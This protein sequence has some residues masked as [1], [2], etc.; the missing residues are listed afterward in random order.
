MKLEKKLAGKLRKLK[1]LILD[2]DG[3]LT[4]GGIIYAGADTELKA[5]NVKDGH[6][7]KLLKRAGVECAVITSRS[8]AAVGRRTNELGIELVYQGEL[9]KLRA[10]DDI[11]LKTGLSA[12]ETAYMGDDVVD[13]PVIARAGF[14]AAPADAVA[15]VRERV[16]F[17]AAAAGGR[18]AVREVAELIL[19]SQG[20]WDEL[21]GRYIT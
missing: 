13:L 1:L 8:S 10:Y 12:S 5:F 18:G 4:D 16:D 9:D 21:M 3:V 19:K 6:G 20:R 2:V 11:L 7:I 14:S 15:E 17:V